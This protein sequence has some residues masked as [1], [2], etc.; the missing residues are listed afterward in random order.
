M[1]WQY[2]VLQEKIQKQSQ[3]RQMRQ[4]I[5]SDEKYEEQSSIVSLNLSSRAKDEKDSSIK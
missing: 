2:A 1:F 3:A 5:P 4:R